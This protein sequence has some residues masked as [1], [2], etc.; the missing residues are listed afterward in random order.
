MILSFPCDISFYTLPLGDR[1]VLWQPRRATTPMRSNRTL[2]PWIGSILVALA[3]QCSTLGTFAEPVDWANSFDASDSILHWLPFGTPAPLITWDGALDACGEA[4]SGSVRIVQ[5]FTGASNEMFFVMGAFIDTSNN[6][7][8]VDSSRYI[9]VGFDLRVDPASA[10]TTR[11][12]FGPLD[13]QLVPTDGPMQQV[14]TFRIPAVATNW[15]RVRLA[16]PPTIW[17]PPLWALY[18]QMWSSGECTNTLAINLDNFGLEGCDCAPPPRLEMTHPTPGLHLIPSLGGAVNQRQSI[19]TRSAAY[20]WMDAPAAVTYSVDISQFPS[21]EWPHEPGY[22]AHLFLVP[23]HDMPDG[24]ADSDID[25]NA[26]NVVYLQIAN[27]SDGR[28]MAQFMFKTNQ[29]SAGSM[30]TNADPALGP[31]GLLATLEALNPHGPWSLTFNVNT[32]I[33]LS[34]PDGSATNFC[35]PAPV[36]ALFRNPLHAYFGV[37]PNN[38]YNFGAE[39][40]IPRIQITGANAA[41]DE[42]FAAPTLDR[43]VWGY[44][45]ADPAGIFPVP[46]GNWSWLEWVGT[47][48]G[49]VL[50]ASTNLLAGSWYNTDLATNIVVWGGRKRL[51]LPPPGPGDPSVMFFRAFREPLRRCGGRY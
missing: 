22:Q 14:G 26:T 15:I 16:M 49:Y 28:A 3:F 40:V 9:A 8:T 48:R 19:Y 2:Q 24:P 39:T 20:S 31:A 18:F 21:S 44:A 41:L 17:P 12:D 6:M 13:I 51:L 7:A 47:D 37:S 29:G 30:F 10:L 42:S 23:P 45:A 1:W 38:A 34:A 5:N 33:R 46:A 50:Q 27:L 36:A 32:N 43:E 35:L 25:W 11:G 4:H